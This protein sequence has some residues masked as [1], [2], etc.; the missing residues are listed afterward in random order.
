MEA[1]LFRQEAVFEN[2]L[3]PILSAWPDLTFILGT[4]CIDSWKNVDLKPHWLISNSI[5][6]I[7]FILPKVYKTNAII[8]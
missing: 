2:Q 1:V 5:G 4:I 6:C 3:N 8:I 7:K